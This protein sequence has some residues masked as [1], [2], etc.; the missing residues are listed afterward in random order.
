MEEDLTEFFLKTVS[1]IV[2]RPRHF[3][4]A[5][6]QVLGKN[7]EVAPVASAPALLQPWQKLY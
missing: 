4:A 7:F 5:P 6:A 2:A 3:D 1:W